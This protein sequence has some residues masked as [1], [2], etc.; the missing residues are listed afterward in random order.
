MVGGYVYFNVDY[1]VFTIAGSTTAIENVQTNQVQGT[2]ILRDGMLLIEKNGK[3]Y[4]ATGA[5][6]K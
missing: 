6:V 5:E 3:L 1:I 4:N 2:K